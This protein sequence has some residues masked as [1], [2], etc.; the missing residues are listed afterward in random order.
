MISVIMSLGALLVAAPFV[1]AAPTPAPTAAAVANGSAGQG[2]E[3]SPPVAELSAKPGETVTV[4]IRV[5]NVTKGELIAKGR[6]DDFSAG[7]NEDGEPKLLLEE[8]GATRYSLKYWV[9]SVPDLRLAPQELKTNVIKIVVPAN[10]EPG[11]HFGVVRFTA[12]PPNLE[13]T[14]VALSASVGALILLKVSG[15]ITEKLT[16]AEFSASRPGGKSGQFFEYGPIDFLVRLRNEGSVHEK[17]KGT[18]DVKS[19]TGKRV[20]TVVVNERGGNVLP[21][22]IRRYEQNLPKKQLFGYYT[23]NLA[24]DYS[25][26][27]KLSGS[28]GFW[29][30]PW[31]LIGLALIGLIVLF[32]LLK[33][34]IKR[35]NAHIIAQARRR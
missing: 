23:A 11:G 22:S 20:A 2:L 26:D 34:G 12:V 16:L 29:V 1:S 24:L 4:N 17:V 35:Y 8:T 9:Q 30:I 13:G 21:D 15:D 25:T 7:S 14:G 33:L 19:W 6:A 18:I 28:L 5:R 32:F 3:I 31:K 10:A 27:K